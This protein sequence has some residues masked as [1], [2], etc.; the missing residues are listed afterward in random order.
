[1]CGVSGSGKT[2]FSKILEK[3]GYRR[4]SA[5][6]I[7]WED[8]GDT[9]VS[10]PLDKRKGIFSDASLKIERELK[11]AIQRGEKIVL[12]STMCKRAKR[13][14]ISNLCRDASINPMFIY[15]KASL[16]LLLKRISQRKGHDAND[17]IVTEDQL[18]IFFSNFESPDID[19]IYI[20]I[21]Q[22]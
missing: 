18:Q 20:T 4:L 8:Y 22:T 13:D 3:Y 19:E 21:E 16:P 11:K 10:L 15:L 1:M 6:E 7:I 14:R 9:F 5:D 17:Q 2:Y 12:D